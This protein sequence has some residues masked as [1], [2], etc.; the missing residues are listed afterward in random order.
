M[1]AFQLVL[2]LLL[3]AVLGQASLLNWVLGRNPLDSDKNFD[4]LRITIDTILF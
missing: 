3:L 4:K 2:M 1:K